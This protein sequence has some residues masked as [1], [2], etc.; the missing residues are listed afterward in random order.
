MME[1][2]LVPDDLHRH[3]ASGTMIS[4]LQNLTERSLP[5]QS[6]DLVSIGEMIVFHNEVIS[7]LVVVSVVVGRFLPRRSLLG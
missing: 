4:T 1:P 3:R 2:L 6:D 7:S 5:E